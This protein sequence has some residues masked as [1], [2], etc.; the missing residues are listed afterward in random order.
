MLIH[1]A[2]SYMKQGLQN[3][4]P[5]ES[6]KKHTNTMNKND[7]NVSNEEVEKFSNLADKW[8]DPHG[9]FRPLHQINPVRLMY[10]RSNLCLHFNLN[11]QNMSP[12]LNLS[13]LDIGCG[14]G[15]IAEPL[16]KM[17]ANVTAIDA[18]EKNINAAHIHSINSGL[19]INYK[20]VT[21]ESLVD[22]GIKFDVVLALETIEHVKDLASFIKICSLLIKPNGAV[23]F[24]TLNRTPKS[25]VLGIIAAEY[26]LG[27]LPR[28]T[29]DWK[30]FVKPSELVSLMKQE[31]MNPS[32]ISGLSYNPLTNDW[33]KTNNL[34]VNYILF[35]EKIIK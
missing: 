31:Q 7:H 8:W 1:T 12:L 3:M 15:L 16:A 17:G 11:P 10:I 14:G 29:H 4:E 26:V 6:L 18:S 22:K 5:A 34:S 28:G 21:A 30:K 9:P 24:S 19:N 25:W 2:Q 32:D 20:S 23:F 35:G 27:W 33:S 13:I